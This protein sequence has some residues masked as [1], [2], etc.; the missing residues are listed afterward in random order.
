MTSHGSIKKC[1]HHNGAPM[2]AVK[3]ARVN[4]K[5]ALVQVYISD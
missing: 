3:I 5:I 4:M 1:T 2:V